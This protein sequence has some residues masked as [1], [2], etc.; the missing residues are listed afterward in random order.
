MGESPFVKDKR[1]I[2]ASRGNFTHDFDDPKNS[3]RPIL[4]EKSSPYCLWSAIKSDALKG[5]NGE[6]ANFGVRGLVRPMFRWEASP[7]GKRGYGRRTPTRGAP[8]AIFNCT[9]A[10]EAQIKVSDKRLR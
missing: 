8:Y 3:F 5:R 9:L 10:F 7:Q 1:I 4:D 2:G 6:A